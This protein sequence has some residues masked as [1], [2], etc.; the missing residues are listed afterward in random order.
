MI[1]TIKNIKKVC[2]LF[3]WLSCLVRAEISNE[4]TIPIDFS[5][6]NGE[7]S[8]LLN[9]S[10]PDSIKVKKTIIYSQQFGDKEFKEIAILPSETF[11]FLDTNC[12]PGYRY[13][14]KILIQDIHNKFFSDD[15]KNF[16]FG[17]CDI[18]QNHFSFD[19]NIQSVSNLLVKYIKNKLL[20]IQVEDNFG[21]LLEVLDTEEIKN[22][23]WIEKF[24][25]PMLNALSETIDKTNGI[26][27]NS[28]FY[29]DIMDYESLYRNHLFLT[30]EMWD[31]QI[32]NAIFI[33]RS[34]WMTLHNR[35]PDAIEMLNKL[36]PFRI[37]ASENYS[38]KPSKIILSVFHEHK[39][40]SKEWY[41][42]SRDEYINLE[43]FIVS[44]VYSFS[45]DIPNNWNYVSLMV[46][47]SIV[48]KETSQLNLNHF[49]NK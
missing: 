22:Y 30:P 29:Y 43:K 45:V 36:D 8:I 21:R 44:D 6:Y 15:S 27:S 23:D 25:S 33:I 48:Q 19:K 35:Y 13:F 40:R 1:S 31:E 37:V 3:I 41:I 39:E 17:S 5:V 7:G 2:Y 38:L 32:Y 4:V 18:I 47:D 46:D 11:F 49:Q 12:A 42:L 10:I 20:P 24:P 34:N 26:I 28:N 16:P 14:Y 9:W